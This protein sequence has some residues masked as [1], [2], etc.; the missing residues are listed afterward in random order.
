MLTLALVV[1]TALVLPYVLCFVHTDDWQ[2]PLWMDSV[3]VGADIVFM[4]DILMNFF[5]GY[6]RDLDATL[7]TDHRLIASNYLRG[8]FAIDLAGSVP[9][10]IVGLL[11]SAA[12]GSL[13]GG[14]GGTQILKILKVPKL[15]RLG[16]L[17]KALAS[18]VDGAANV[19]RIVLL[20][21]ML[22]MLIH[23]LASLFYILSVS[24][25]AHGWVSQRVC[26]RPED[27]FTPISWPIS[28]VGVNNTRSSSEVE[29]TGCAPETPS[30]LNHFM[31][32][33]TTYYFT[34]LMLMGDDVSPTHAGEYAYLAIVA[35]LGACV[36]ATIFANVASLV[37]QLTA[38]STR[39]QAKIDSIDRAMSQLALDATTVKRIRGYYHYRWTRHR[40]H[41]GEK[42]VKDLPYQLRTRTSCM[43]HEEMI[44]KCALFS[45]AD[46][47]FIAALSTVLMAEVFLPAQFIA[48]AGY[49]SRA[50][51]FI[52]RG[53]VQIIRKVDGD[54]LMEECFDFFDVLGLFS[55]RQHTTSI[56]SLTHVDLYRLN[57]DDFEDIVR[58]YPAQGLA[59]ADA[60]HE[61]FKPVYASVAAKRLYEL[62]GMPNL[63]HVFNKRACPASGGGWREHFR[64]TGIAK[65]IRCVHERAM[66]MPEWYRQRIE[67]EEVK[68]ARVLQKRADDSFKYSLNGTRSDSRRRT[69]VLGCEDLGDTLA[70]TSSRRRSAAV[71]SDAGEEK[72][73]ARRRRV[74]LFP[75]A[76]REPSAKG[77]RPQS[78]VHNGAAACCDMLRKTHEMEASVSELRRTQAQTHVMLLSS[79]GSLS[80]Q[81]AALEV[82]QEQPPSDSNIEP[83]RLPAPTATQPP[84]AEAAARGAR[85][86]GF[87]NYA[88]E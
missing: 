88:V 19:S 59:M 83:A 48:I 14:A 72:Q 57:R 1:Y 78:R 79:V 36:N 54:F 82:H 30:T 18:L 70:A 47:K 87:A 85:R 76:S 64:V 12:G 55:A 42:F 52:R 67:A 41:A 62:A 68:V 40:D 11:M 49:V 26:E 15:L 31:V 35:L 22:A 5:T 34:L 61:H 71:S 51:F 7:I 27:Y 33:L 17:I 4:I 66:Q 45:E 86:V 37:A 65:R 77:S 84:N 50:M 53:R 24:F 29:A 81:L 9:W 8:W 60:A 58:H 75:V 69:V 6:V 32:Y 63:L 13:T 56:R 16:R 3:D 73:G 38:P 74:S 25:D 10:T 2:A 43:V 39:H 80:R 23:G 46:R 20:I 21:L 44:R 28:A